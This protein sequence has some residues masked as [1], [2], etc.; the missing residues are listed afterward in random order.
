MQLIYGGVL[1]VESDS[2]RHEL[3]QV[4][5]LFFPASPERTTSSTRH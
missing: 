4:R 2:G 5:Q 3:Q 1:E